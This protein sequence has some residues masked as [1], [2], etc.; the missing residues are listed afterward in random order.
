M[1][2]LKIN[3][4]YIGKKIGKGTFG[5]VS[6]CFDQKNAERRV[7]KKI[8]KERKFIE[9]SKKE[10][11]ILNMLKDDTEPII[12]LIDN[13]IHQEIQ[14]LVFEYMETNLY[15]YYKNNNIPYK[16]VIYIMYEIA[17]GLEFIHKNKII[18]CDLKPENIMLHNNAPNPPSKGVIEGVIKDMGL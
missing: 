7:I 11:K 16:E 4:F 12:R 8:R 5:E 9:Y 6:V 15:E 17:R 14:Y 1:D 13:F 10:I 3:N 2:V 18:H